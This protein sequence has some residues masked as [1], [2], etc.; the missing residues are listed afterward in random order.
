MDWGRVLSELWEYHRGKT[1]GVVVGLIFGLMVVFF[2]FFQAVFISLCM[3]AGYF[4][5]RRIDENIGFHDVVDR[6]FRD[7]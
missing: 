2:G 5:G 1:V 6:L 3:L 7:R 4:V